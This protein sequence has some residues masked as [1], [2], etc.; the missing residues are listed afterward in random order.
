MPKKTFSILLTVAA[1]LALVACGGDED[2]LLERYTPL[3][4]EG[5]ESFAANGYLWQASLDTLAFMPMNSTDGAGGVII[6]DWYTHPS[7][8]YERTKVRVD[9]KDP[10]LR[11]DALKVTVNRQTQDQSG[12]WIDVPV[13]QSTVAG[14]EDAILIQAR[15]IRLRNVTSE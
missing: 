4:M 7:S 8:P 13:Q 3:S 14:I 9:I 1:S 15:Q 12:N 6:T 11:S 2:P 10:R 5:A